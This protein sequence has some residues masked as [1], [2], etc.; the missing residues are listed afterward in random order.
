MM[1]SPQCHN[2]GSYAHINFTIIITPGLSNI[3]IFDKYNPPFSAQR[4]KKKVVSL[5]S[6]FGNYA[7][8]V[9]HW[10]ARIDPSLMC[11]ERVFAVCGKIN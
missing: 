7:F 11:R 2:S 8:H 3:T 10:S 9:G 4:V 1:F 5:R 6:Q